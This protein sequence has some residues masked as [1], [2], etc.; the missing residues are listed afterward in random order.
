MSLKL[1][2][3][4]RWTKIM[5]TS[6]KHQLTICYLNCTVL[7]NCCLSFFI[8]IIYFNY[9]ILYYYFF[10]LFPYLSVMPCQ[11]TTDENWLTQLIP[12]HLKKNWEMFIN[13]H[14]PFS[15]KRINNITVMPSLSIPVFLTPLTRL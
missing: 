12:V 7:S 8:I 4:W 14:C 10:L 11:G 2:W 15:N 13:V 9:I 5:D 1:P 6:I 3:V